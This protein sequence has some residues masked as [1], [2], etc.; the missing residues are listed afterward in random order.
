MIKM[1]DGQKSGA[2]LK[3]EVALARA[4]ILDEDLCYRA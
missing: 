2:P 4:N 3:G 1:G